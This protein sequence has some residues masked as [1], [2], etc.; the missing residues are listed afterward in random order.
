MLL[1]P[2]LL[3]L[4]LAYERG[5]TVWERPNFHSSPAISRS[6]N[7]CLEVSDLSKEEVDLFD[8]YS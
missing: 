3:T 4:W 1:H 7:A 8:F 6:L 2:R 5:R